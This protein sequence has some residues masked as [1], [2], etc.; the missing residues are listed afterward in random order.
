L[1][2]VKDQDNSKTLL[3]RKDSSELDAELGCLASSS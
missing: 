2:T 1:R 3:V